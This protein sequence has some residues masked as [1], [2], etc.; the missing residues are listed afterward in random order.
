MKLNVL[1]GTL[2]LTKESFLLMKSFFIECFN[3]FR[4]RDKRIFA[5]KLALAMG[6]GGQ[7][8]ISEHLVISRVTLRKAIREITTNIPIEDKFYLRRR[9]RVEEH[10]PN[11]LADI[12]AVV[13]SQSQTDPNFHSTRLF[14]RLTVAEIRRQLIAKKGYTDEE[15]PSNQ[16][17]NTKVNQM[18]YGLK[19]VQKTKPLKKNQGN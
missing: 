2:V 10:L 18:G 13:D 12:K 11:L 9:K 16:T 5:A 19:K 15:L 4:G 3:K 7:V 6:R 17:L 14:T 8:F 1:P